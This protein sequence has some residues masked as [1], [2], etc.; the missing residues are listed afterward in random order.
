MHTKVVGEAGAG[1]IG[2][3]PGFPF[4][5]C[6]SPSKAPALWASFPIGQVRSWW[7]SFRFGILEISHQSP[8][9]LEV[10]E[11]GGCLLRKNWVS[12]CLFPASVFLLRHPRLVG[13]T[14]SLFGVRL[15]VCFFWSPVLW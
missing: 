4:R 14:S 11:N 10:T 13:R 9:D 6:W 12:P 1:R 2:R 7:V 3:V 5:L 8:L 15:R